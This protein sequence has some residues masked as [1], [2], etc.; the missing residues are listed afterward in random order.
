VH[1]WGVDAGS[2]H[3]DQWDVLVGAGHLA[4]VDDELMQVVPVE[5]AVLQPL[6]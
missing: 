3:C 1:I 2:C 6:N 5:G 4:P